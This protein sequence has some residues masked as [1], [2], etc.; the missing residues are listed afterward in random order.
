VA[1]SLAS[2]WSPE[3]KESAELKINEWVSARKADKVLLDL[4]KMVKFYDAKTKTQN[5]KEDSYKGEIVQLERQ[6]DID[7]GQLASVAGSISGIEFGIKEEEGKAAECRKNKDYAGALKSEAEIKR[8]EIDRKS[9]LAKR[10]SIST[11][12]NQNLD[13]YSTKRN[14][15]FVMTFARAESSYSLQAHTS[16]REIV[17]NMVEDYRKCGIPIEIK[18]GRMK[19]REIGKIREQIGQIQKEFSEV[20]GEASETG[21][22]TKPMDPVCLSKEYRAAMES[23]QKAKEDNYSRAVQNI[24]AFNSI[25]HNSPIL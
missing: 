20:I 2:S 24:E 6:I 21:H 16:Y 17:K 23:M 15:Y 9:I 14:F 4:D 18:E 11:R 5:N 7:Q 3:W 12:V 1:V 13:I 22:Y 10:D 8:M 25:R 19:L